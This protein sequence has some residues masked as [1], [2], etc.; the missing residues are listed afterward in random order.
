MNKHVM[1][2]LLCLSILIAHTVSGQVRR[3]KKR[4]SGTTSQQIGSQWWI[5]VR[6]G[7][8]F[9][10]AMSSR[11]YSVFSFTSNQNTSNQD[12]EYSSY[13]LPG[14]QFGFSAGFE[15]LRGFSV[16]ILPT[17]SSNRFD[18]SSSYQWS[19]V[20]SA[21]KKVQTNYRIETRLQFV[22]IPMTFKYELTNGR[23]KPYIQAGGYFGLLTDAIK[24]V[25]I[26]SVDQASGASTEI[27]VS[28]LAEGIES[29]TQQHNYGILGGGG[30]TY[31]LGNAR[32]GL[33]INYQHG[34]QNLDNGQ[35]KYTDNQLVSGIYDVPDDYSL[36]SV[37]ISLQIIMPLKFITSR[38]YVPL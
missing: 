14:L 13:N 23:L 27:V 19:D 4:T 1:A 17:Y 5:G 31:N 34:L 38:D 2:C 26:T 37:D 30:F 25:D 33:E 10:K 28:E 11:Q 16:N 36:N 22:Q 20:E 21:N 7:T 3:S 35:M 24:K 6:G 29:R 32:I 8:N 12:K 9:S 18:Y 15:F